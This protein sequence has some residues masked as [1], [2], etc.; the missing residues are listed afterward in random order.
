MTVQLWLRCQSN[1]ENRSEVLT[2]LS[3]TVA[4][5]DRV[6]AWMVERHWKSSLHKRPCR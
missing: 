5:L 6:V 3:E 4:A 1:S 2:T